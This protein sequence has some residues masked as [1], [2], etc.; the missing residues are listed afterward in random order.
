[1]FICDFAKEN[2]NLKNPP[3]TGTKFKFKDPIRGTAFEHEYRNQ[4]IDQLTYADTASKIGLGIGIH[5][6]TNMYLNHRYDKSPKFKKF[7][8]THS[9]KLNAVNLGIIGASVIIPVG[10][11]YA[12]KGL[13]KKLKTKIAKDYNYVPE[14]GKKKTNW[15]AKA[16]ARLAHLV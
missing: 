10:A 5:K 11:S 14:G 9:S 16:S 13:N 15:L 8:D 6:F 12:M 4:A 3:V 2:K 1:M 7:V